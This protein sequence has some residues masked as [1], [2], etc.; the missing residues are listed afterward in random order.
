[1]LDLADRLLQRQ[2]LAGDLG[3]VER[4]LHAAQ[5]RHQRS[6]RAL[7]ERTAVLAGVLVETGDSARDERLIVGHL[8]RQVS[9]G[10]RIRIVSSRSGL[11]DSSATGQPI[12]SSVRR[13]Y[14]MAWAGSSAHD[15]ARAVPSC[16]A[17]AVS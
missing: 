8:L 4:R 9:N 1:G 12:S 2:P 3:L 13:T 15:R 10:L 5:L 7:V 16:Q 14:L 17:S 6:P 11:V